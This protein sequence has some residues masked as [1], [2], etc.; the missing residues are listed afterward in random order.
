MTP[1][2]RVCAQQRSTVGVAA[3]ADRCCTHER[4]VI[5]AT[6][7]IAVLGVAVR[8]EWVVGVHPVRPVVAQ[9]VGPAAL[10]KL[11]EDV[12][13]AVVLDHAAD[14]VDG[15]RLRAVAVGEVAWCAA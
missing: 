12:E 14:V 4:A 11:V 7:V 13:D 1:G 6:G 8:G 15:H 3:T 2:A 10:A 5:T 9:R